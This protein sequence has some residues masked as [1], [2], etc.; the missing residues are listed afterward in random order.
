MNETDDQQLQKQARETL[1]RRAET[2]DA[3]TLSRLNQARQR[4]VAASQATSHVRWLGWRMAGAAA[5]VA[6]IALTVL[7]MGEPTPSLP[8]NGLMLSDL[9]LID[10]D[11]DLELVAEPEFY[12]WLAEA[13]DG[14]GDA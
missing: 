11:D 8:N 12:D 14:P 13:A 9:E 4:A 7:L 6:G 3:A 5:A 10:L 1:D 2:L